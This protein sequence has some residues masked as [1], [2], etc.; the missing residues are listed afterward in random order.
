MTAPVIIENYDP[1]WP[2][3]FETLRAPINATLGLLA[4]AIEHVGSTAVPGLAAKPIIDID[5]LLRSAADVPLAITRLT[6]LGYQHQGDLGVLGREAFRPPPG[7]IPHHL[8]ACPPDS[9]AYRSHIEFRDHLR[10]H[11]QDVGAYATLKRSLAESV[12]DREA[13]TQAKTGFIEEILRRTGDS[14]RK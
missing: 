10:N 12:V 8:Y 5:I 11:P 6:F 14:H 9:R 3:K 1:L 4:A 7:A 13:Y 2:E